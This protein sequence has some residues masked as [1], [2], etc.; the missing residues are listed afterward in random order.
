VRRLAIR[1]EVPTWN[2]WGII[3]WY[4]L[5]GPARTALFAGCGLFL[6]LFHEF[7]LA[8]LLA[9]TS[10]TVW[11]FDGPAGGL[12]LPESLRHCVAPTICTW[13][14]CGAVTWQLWNTPVRSAETTTGD[15]PVSRL[16]AVVLWSYLLIAL[17]LIVVYP[18]VLIGQEALP[19]VLA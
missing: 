12:S 13:V 8:S 18:S 11:L 5:Q 3:V 15:I 4:W 14:V 6:M 7:E 10:W 16:G 2:R 1:D 17:S 9:T 19:G